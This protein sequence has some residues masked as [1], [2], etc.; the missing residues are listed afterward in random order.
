MA[1]PAFV[2]YGG[3]RGGAKA[4]AERIEDLCIDSEVRYDG[5]YPL[6]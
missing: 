6:G 2:S 4:K 3:H 5:A 1:V